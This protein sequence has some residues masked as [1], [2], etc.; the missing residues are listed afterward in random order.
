MAEIYKY[1]T[2]RNAAKLGLVSSDPR[3]FTFRLSIGTDPE[4]YDQPL[5]IEVA[6][7]KSWA[8]DRIAVQDAQGKAIAVRTMQAGDRVVLRF[9]IVPRTADYTIELNP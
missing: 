5:T 8:P 1:Q 3:R 4:L 6:P 7:P 9:E 2:V